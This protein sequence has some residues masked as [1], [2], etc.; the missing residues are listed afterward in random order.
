[1]NIKNLW[2]YIR[3]MRQNNALK[4]DIPTSIKKKFHITIENGRLKLTPKNE[5]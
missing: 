1:M 5:K 2:K 3:K 4:R